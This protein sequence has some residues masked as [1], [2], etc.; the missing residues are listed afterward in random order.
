MSL[1]R[2]VTA[3]CPAQVGLTTAAAQ[4]GAQPCTAVFLQADPANGTNVLIGG[5]T[6]QVIVLTPGT[7]L[8]ATITNVNAFYAVMVSG[9]GNLNVM[10]FE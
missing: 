8:T 9:T 10:Y 1:Y 6:N 2:P 4:L 3:D 5:A 7:S